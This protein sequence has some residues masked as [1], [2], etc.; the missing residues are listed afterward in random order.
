MQVRL[1]IK[2]PLGLRPSPSQGRRCGVMGSVR[3]AVSFKLSPFGGA[4]PFWDQRYGKWN[5]FR[6]MAGTRIPLMRR[7]FADVF[8]VREHCLSCPVLD[9][10]VLGVN[11]FIPFRLKKD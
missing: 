5:L 6:F 7:T 1:Q 2:L 4:E 8:Y 9:T 11:F 10:D 3:A